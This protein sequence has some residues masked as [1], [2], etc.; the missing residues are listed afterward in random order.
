MKME[1]FKTLEDLM[2]AATFAEKNQ[3]DF[4]L[5]LMA[6]EIDQKQ[7]RQIKA[8]NNEQ[9]LHRPQMRL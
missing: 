7:S 1:L 8:K 6:D 9:D 4:A 3:H 2:T 5:K